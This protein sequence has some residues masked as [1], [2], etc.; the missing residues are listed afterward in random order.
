MQTWRQTE[1][2]QMLRVTTIAAD[3][4]GEAVSDNRFD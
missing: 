3:P 4:D 2:L 1:L